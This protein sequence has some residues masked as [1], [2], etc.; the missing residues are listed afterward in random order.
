MFNKYKFLFETKANINKK[1]GEH[2]PYGYLQNY[3]NQLPAKDHYRGDSDSSCR[4]S[5]PYKSIFDH[6]TSIYRTI[7]NE[8]ID[9]FLY[10]KK[11][12]KE[13]YLIIKKILNLYPEVDKRQE[14]IDYLIKQLEYQRH[15]DGRNNKKYT[16]ALIKLLIAKEFKYD[17]YYEMDLTKYEKYVNKI[18]RYLDYCYKMNIYYENKVKNYSYYDFHNLNKLIR[19]YF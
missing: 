5:Y 18:R 8:L 3:F 2:E 15:L 9:D 13:L 10:Y 14:I 1:Y 12:Q 4:A 17:F 19:S 16:K 11:L 7:F 6:R